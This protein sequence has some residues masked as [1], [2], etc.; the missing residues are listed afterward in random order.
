MIAVDGTVHNASTYA[1]RGCR[2]DV[3]RA[4]HA[5]R[6]AT[7]RATLRRWVAAHGLP[8]HVE[9]GPSAYNNWGC[10]CNA[11]RAGNAAAGFASYHARK[12]A[13]A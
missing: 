13:A 6:M 8:D 9:H 4:A 11:C 7:R 12:R 5:A 1:H 3:C 10:R 2:C